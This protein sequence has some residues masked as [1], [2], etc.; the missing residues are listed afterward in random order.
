MKDVST[1]RPRDPRKVIHAS[2][3]VH[4]GA[5][6]FTNLVLSQREGG[7]ELNPHSDGSC[8]LTLARDEACALRDALTEWLA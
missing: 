8:T 7:I 2:C 5:A 3:S 6:G 1:Q 4:Q